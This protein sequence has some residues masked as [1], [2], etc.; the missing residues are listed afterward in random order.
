MQ[1]LR[2]RMRKRGKGYAGGF[3]LAIDHCS[4]SGCCAKENCHRQSLSIIHSPA[5]LKASSHQSQSTRLCLSNDNVYLKIV[6]VRG[7][8]ET[9][10]DQ[11]D[12]SIDSIIY[13]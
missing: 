11:R 10:S 9:E 5:R 12:H 2:D 13:G 4:E 6:V 8:A 7:A 3:H 1:R